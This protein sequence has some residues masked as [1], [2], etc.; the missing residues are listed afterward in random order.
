VRE[1]LAKLNSNKALKFGFCFVV[2][3]ILWLITLV[4]F[5]NTETEVP[6]KVVVTQ[7]A[8]GIV[9]QE[10]ENTKIEDTTEDVVLRENLDY[11]YVSDVEYVRVFTFQEDVDFNKEFVENTLR[12]QMAQEMLDN[13]M[14]DNIS[15]G[16]MMGS[17]KLEE[18]ESTNKKTAFFEYGSVKDMQYAGVYVK[19]GNN[20]V[21]A[22]GYARRDESK[23]MLV[24]AIKRA[25]TNVGDY[26]QQAREEYSNR[27]D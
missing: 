11:K 21:Y 20:F 23:E 16:Q 27:E 19:V 2:A 7:K 10:N 24:N 22:A 5:P 8:P 6:A 13:D 12:P 9:I 18:L 17:W 26:I 15:V 3:I 4:L 14:F 25:N 1:F